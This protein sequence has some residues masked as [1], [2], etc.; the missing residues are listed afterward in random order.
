MVFALEQQCKKIETLIDYKKK[1]QE[2]NDFHNLI[3]QIVDPGESNN[4]NFL[5]LFIRN[6]NIV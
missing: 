1:I 4:Y 2:K 6:L 3:Y 5:V